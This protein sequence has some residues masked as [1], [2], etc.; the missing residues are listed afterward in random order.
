IANFHSLVRFF[1]CTLHLRR[2]VCH[3]F[4]S[5]D[6]RKALVT[7]PTN[8]FTKWPALKAQMSGGLT[9]V[10]QRLEQQYKITVQHV[11]ERKPDVCVYVNAMAHERDVKTSVREMNTQLT[12]IGVAGPNL[13][14]RTISHSHGTF[15]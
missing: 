6:S 5:D 7:I 3:L 12:H 8:H 1:Y 10:V 4:V 13:E 14:V 9:I 2:D 15:F 11:L